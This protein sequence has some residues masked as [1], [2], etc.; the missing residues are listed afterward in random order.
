M[1]LVACCV[2]TAVCVFETFFGVVQQHS[3]R[4]RSTPKIR[5][6]DDTSPKNVKA[7]NHRLS[8]NKFLDGTFIV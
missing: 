5:E 3:V 6:K 1:M 8:L 7:I 4:P 2:M